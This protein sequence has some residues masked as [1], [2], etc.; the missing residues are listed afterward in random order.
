MPVLPAAP[1]CCPPPPPGLP[2]QATP[3]PVICGLVG[4]RDLPPHPALSHSPSQGEVLEV[5]PRGGAAVGCKISWL[6][7]QCSVL[8]SPPPSFALNPT[9]GKITSVAS[10]NHRITNHGT[11]GLEGTLQPITHPVPTLAMGWLPASRSGCPLSEAFPLTSNLSLP[12][13]SLKPFPA[14]NPSSPPGDA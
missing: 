1:S 13:F 12:S 8:G 9:V 5:L 10:Q 2:G 14:C 3:A 11:V 7:H 6:E 4:K